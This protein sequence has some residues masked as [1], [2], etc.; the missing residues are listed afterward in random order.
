MVVV[1]RK[2]K[3]DEGF[4]NVWIANGEEMVKKGLSG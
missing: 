3:E 2:S 1:G 4:N